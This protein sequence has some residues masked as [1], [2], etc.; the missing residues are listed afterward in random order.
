MRSA[1]HSVF[2][3]SLGA[4]EQK[5]HTKTYAVA[6]EVGEVGEGS[7]AS[8]CLSQVGQGRPIKEINP[9]IQ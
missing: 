8:P 7:A 6:L 4:L 9:F 1:F 3:P 2:A 5:Q